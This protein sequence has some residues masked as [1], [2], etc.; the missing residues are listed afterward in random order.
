MTCIKV[1]IDESRFNVSLIGGTKSQDRVHKPQLLK[2]KEAE[3]V[4]NRGPYAY[5]PNVLPL[6][7]TVSLKK[8]F[9]SRRTLFILPGVDA[10]HVYVYVRARA[11]GCFHS[12]IST[13]T[14]YHSVISTETFPQSD[15]YRNLSEG[16]D[17]VGGQLRGD[18][19]CPFS[20]VTKSGRVW[21]KVPEN[22]ARSV[23]ANMTVLAPSRP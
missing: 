21:R 22:G 13:E 7:Q 14:F 20:G 10:S 2:R 5:Q 11:L 16:A 3:A 23:G 6:G 19:E 15:Q 1:G 9:Q 18:K 4:S 12:L 17:R 8:S